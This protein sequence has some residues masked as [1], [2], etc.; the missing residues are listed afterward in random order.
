VVSTHR[1]YWVSNPVR[2]RERRY[3]DEFATNTNTTPAYSLTMGLLKSG[4]KEGNFHRLVIN[5]PGMSH[6]LCV[7][8]VILQSIFKRE[9]FETAS[10]G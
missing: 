9:A 2:I 1:G 5:L 7:T 6:I 10:C 3:P 8:A 4:N